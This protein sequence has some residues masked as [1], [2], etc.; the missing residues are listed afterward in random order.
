MIKKLIGTI[1]STSMEKTVTVKI[2]RIFR[3]PFYKKVIKRHG[4]IMAHTEEKFAVGDI[5]EIAPTRPVSKN[6]HFKVVQKL[7]VKE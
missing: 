5:V 1:V 3:H 7:E 2:E 6:K 4:K